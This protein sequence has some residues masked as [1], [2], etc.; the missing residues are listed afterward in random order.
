M[1]L[2]GALLFSMGV[3][4]AADQEQMQQ[5]QQQVQVVEQDQQQ[6]Q[7]YGWQLMTPEER[8][9]HFAKMHNFKTEEEREAYRLEH[10]K[11]M[12]ERAKESG[13]TLPE[14]SSEQCEEKGAGEA[15]HGN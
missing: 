4:L 15:G 14:F 12:Q 10:R 11:L 3:G 9:A 6:E 5:D 8:A 7:V 13:V 2:P 1:V